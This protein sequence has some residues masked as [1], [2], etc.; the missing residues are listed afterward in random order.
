MGDKSIADEDSRVLEERD[1]RGG[2]YRYVPPQSVESFDN[3]SLEE[4]DYSIGYQYLEQRT[5][6]FK[7]PQ[8]LGQK[9]RW[10]LQRACADRTIARDT[11]VGAKWGAALGAMAFPLPLPVSVTFG[12][13]VVV[14]GC[15]WGATFGVINGLCA[16]TTRFAID[17]ASGPNNDL[18]LG[19]EPGVEP[20]TT[21]IPERELLPLASMLRRIGVLPQPSAPRG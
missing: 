15:L 20:V 11:Y 18:V 1:Y 8:S 7:K 14:F 19:M 17:W 16:K 6:S 13:P 12:L 5:G 3:K 4:P 10:A 21:I 2:D 9:F